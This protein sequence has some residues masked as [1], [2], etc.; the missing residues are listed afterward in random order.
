[1]KNLKKPKVAENSKELPEISKVAEQLV[2]RVSHK[3]PMS[4]KKVANESV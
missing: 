2:A 3:L 1:M 4:P